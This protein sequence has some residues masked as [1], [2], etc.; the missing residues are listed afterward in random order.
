LRH[1]RFRHS[2]YDSWYR[3][4]RNLILKQ[5]HWWRRNR[6]LYRLL[7]NYKNNAS[8][9]LLFSSCFFQGT[10]KKYCICDNTAI[11]STS[12]IASLSSSGHRLTDFKLK[13]HLWHFEHIIG[14]YL[15]IGNTSDSDGYQPRLTK[16]SWFS[17]IVYHKR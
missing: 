12:N 11:S 17:L 6:I 3:P 14:S 4:I 8:F 1:F 10:S 9:S 7:C 15:K 13:I 2:W 5:R 16:P